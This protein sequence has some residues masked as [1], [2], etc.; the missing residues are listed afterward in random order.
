MPGQAEMTTARRNLEDAVRLSRSM[1]IA[2]G[3]RMLL[4]SSVTM[5]FGKLIEK[6]V[7]LMG[8]AVN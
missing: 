8:C 6:M 5:R 2:I 1:A 7:H 3:I 4:I